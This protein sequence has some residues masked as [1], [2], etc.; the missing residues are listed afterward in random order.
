MNLKFEKYPDGLVPAIVQDAKTSAVL[1]LGYMN[2]E[3]FEQTQS[4]GNVTFFSRS[5]QE[6]WVKGETSGNYL[7]L[8]SMTEDC[9]SDAVL[10][11]ANPIGPT[12]H[13][14]ATTCFGEPDIDALAELESVIADRRTNPTVDSYV[15]KLFSKGLNKIA[16]K[17]GEEAVEVVIAAKDDDIDDFK[18]EAADLLFHYLILLNA[19]GL[20]LTDVRM[21]LALRMN[22]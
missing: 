17:V 1:M 19:K 11:L 3:A 5:R 9:D 18:N 12:C 22:R 6:L 16:Q 15:S 13:T 20:S 7:R 21:E 14:G 10:I 4:S 8:V 2:R